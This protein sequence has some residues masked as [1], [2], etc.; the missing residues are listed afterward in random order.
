MD[1]DSDNGYISTNYLKDIQDG[2]QIHPGINARY[3]RLKIRDRI[4]K[5]QSEWKVAEI[6]ADRMGKVLNKV[7]KDVVIEL[8][9]SFPTLG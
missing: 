7:F 3:V 1:D 9:H 4:K 2:S 8:N 6:S 5:T